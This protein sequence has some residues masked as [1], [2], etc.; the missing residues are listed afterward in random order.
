MPP[1]IGSFAQIILLGL[2]MSCVSSQKDAAQ[3]QSEDDQLQGEARKFSFIYSVRV[4]PTFEALDIFLPIAQSNGQQTITNMVIRSVIDG[5]LSEEPRYGNKFWHAALPD[6]LTDTL[7]I[8]ITYDVQRPE[9]SLQYRNKMKIPTLTDREKE[10]FLSENAHVPVS[11]NLVDSIRT[12]LVQGRPKSLE[13]A[14]SIYNYVID[15]MEYKKIGSG[16]GNGDTY[17]ACDEKYGNCTDFHALFTSLARAE[18]I[19]S[20]F[21]IGFPIPEDKVSGNIGGYHC[22]INFYLPETGWFP[23]DASEAWKHPD[24]KELLFGTQPTDRLQFTVG[25]DLE[26]G[27]GHA[28]G[29]LNYFIYPHLEQ[30]GKLYSGF[31]RSFEYRE[32]G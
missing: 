29:P 23:V 31:T 2:L 15:N 28:S 3:V 5:E 18:Q 25:R 22:W 17:W 30:N 10:L 6:G 27:P 24:K 21:E 19:P 4:D 12:R 13:K 9:N 16:W 26:L 11:G 32:V 20:R 14:R 8:S 1:K 7:D